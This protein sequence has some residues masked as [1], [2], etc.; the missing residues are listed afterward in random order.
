[1][2]ALMIT[3]D[4]KHLLVNLKKDSKSVVI[5]RVQVGSRINDGPIVS[6]TYERTDEVIDGR[7]V[8]REV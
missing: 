7:V 6:H 5:D 4:D 3:K 8:F 2:K 1:M